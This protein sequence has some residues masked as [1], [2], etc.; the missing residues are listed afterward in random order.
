MASAASFADDR[1]SRAMVPPSPVRI[2]LCA[3]VT[4]HCDQ[5]A[6]AGV[7]HCPDLRRRTAGGS[8]ATVR[9]IVNSCQLKQ[10]ASGA[11]LE[12]LLLLNAPRLSFR[13]FAAEVVPSRGRTE[14]FSIVAV[15]GFDVAARPFRA[16][17]ISTCQAAV[18]AATPDSDGGAKAS[19]GRAA[20]LVSESTENK[21]K[22]HCSVA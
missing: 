15:R 10:A 9:R 8:S 1:R 17:R 7:L 20:T 18:P 2:E 19:P 14:L 6:P 4:S 3:A 11:S 16:N 5:I 12:P 21:E 22:A 13:P